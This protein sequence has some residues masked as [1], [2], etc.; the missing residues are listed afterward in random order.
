MLIEIV[1]ILWLA[2]GTIELEV[3]GQIAPAS[4][5]SL[6][7]SSH[8]FRGFLHEPFRLHKGTVG[9]VVIISFQG[10]AGSCEH[11]GS[12]EIEVGV[13]GGEGPHVVGC[14]TPFSVG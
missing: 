10:T 9:E 11:G 1:E 14:A 8:E 12:L 3:S 6:W 7:V 13:S 5:L 2:S 4:L